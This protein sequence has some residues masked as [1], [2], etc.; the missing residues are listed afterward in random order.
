MFALQRYTVL[1]IFTI[2]VSEQPNAQ[3]PVVCGRTQALSSPKSQTYARVTY[4]RTASVCFI[5]EEPHNITC[6]RI[7]QRTQQSQ[8]YVVPKMLQA[9]PSCIYCLL[10]TTAVA[11]IDAYITKCYAHDDTNTCKRSMFCHTCFASHNT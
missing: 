2:A 11:A 5:Q 8:Q 3:R 9:A 6:I 1:H 4:L 10:Y 7:E